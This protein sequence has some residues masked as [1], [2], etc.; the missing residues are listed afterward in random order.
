M[1]CWVGDYMGVKKVIIYI[2]LS[3][4][5]CFVRLFAIDD[6]RIVFV[7]LET[8]TLE[9]DQLLLYNELKKQGIYK[10]QTVL[11]KYDQK[12]LKN[13]FLYL[14]N[15]I[16]QIWYINRSKMVIINDNNYVIS[17]FKR[18]GV[19]VM[20]VW[21]AA[22]AIK[23]FG[24]AIKREYPIRNYDY[25]IANSKYW[26][27]PYQ[28]AFSVPKE[29]IKVVGMPRLDH[30]LD[31]QYHS[32]TRKQLFLKYPILQRKKV[33]LYA[34]TFR[35]NI[36]QGFYSVPLDAQGLM[37][38]LGSGY[39]FIYKLHPLLKD[40]PF[41]DCRY[42]YNMN[43]ESIHD[44]FTITDILISDYSS[45]IFDFS[46][47][48]KPILLYTPDKQSYI[49][50]VGTFVDLEQMP[51]VSCNSE[52]ELYTAIIESKLYIEY[53]TFTDTYFHFQDGKNTDRVVALIT[54]LMET[55]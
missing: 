40:N 43:E 53:K 3:I 41:K 1:Q 18:N 39:I 27:Q 47:L 16:K 13:N 38:S 14:L 15:T 37:K 51:F 22:G 33:I 23:K 20:Q 8:D 46:L 26:L 2:I 6:Q 17:T 54:E 30:L 35:G 52:K 24:N 19:I 29:H 21:H 42:A 25:V 7:S 49:Q 9:N 28:E 44:L 50:D 34:P 36:Y 12:S 55:D 10:L 11:I 4:V 48:H 32:E 45:I 31:A 5:N